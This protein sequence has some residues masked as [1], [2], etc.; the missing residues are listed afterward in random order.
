MNR[1][2]YLYD[3]SLGEYKV[4]YLYTE[5]NN[6]IENIYFIM[7][8]YKNNFGPMK[9]ILQC[10]FIYNTIIIEDMSIY[11]DRISSETLSKE[12]STMTGVED[13]HPCILFYEN[14]TTFIRNDKNVVIKKKTI[15]L[16]PVNNDHFLK[17]FIYNKIKNY[18]YMLYFTQDISN[19]DLQNN[20]ITN[21]IE[22]IIN[23]KITN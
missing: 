18:N 5:S 10:L 4:S 7:F 6:K 9:N 16:H 3:R 14:S 12:L 13:V 1:S 21:T 8:Y 17:G 19:A 20:I 2:N 22:P 11:I 15:S 23:S